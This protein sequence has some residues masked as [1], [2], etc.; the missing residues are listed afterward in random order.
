MS[1]NANRPIIHNIF[2]FVR[3]VT[4]QISGQAETLQQVLLSSPE[5][6]R[7]LLLEALDV[8]QHWWMLSAITQSALVMLVKDMQSRNWILAAKV[9]NKLD[10]KIRRDVAAQLS[11][12]TRSNVLK[13]LSILQKV[14][15]LEFTTD[16]EFIPDVYIRAGEWP[17][18]FPVRLRTCSLRG[19]SYKPFNGIEV[20]DESCMDSFHEDRSCPP[21]S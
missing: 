11:E 9:I 4:L 10:L 3:D 13:V 1:E 15:E 7:R 2:K 8:V 16:G 12:T 17:E 5:G 21:S 18:L 20:V 6:D 19:Q 14:A